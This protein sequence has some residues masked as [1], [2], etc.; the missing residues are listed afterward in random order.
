[1][2]IAWLTFQALSEF[3]CGNVLR[4]A[5]HARRGS[6][7][8]GASDWLTASSAA[9]PATA[10]RPSSAALPHALG[11]RVSYWDALL[12]ATAA[13]AGCTWVLTEDMADGAVL[14]GLRIH[15]PFAADGNL[16]DLTRQLLDL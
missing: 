11:G 13:E 8:A 7:G 4:K 1:M 6:G 5:H 9:S 2:S 12:V 3:Y 15:N 10:S 16:T 14:E